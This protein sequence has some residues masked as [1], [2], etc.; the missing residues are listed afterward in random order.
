MVENIIRTNKFHKDTFDKTTEERR[1][2]VLNVAIEEFALNG[3]NATSINDISKKAQISIG[4]MYSYFASKE[5]LF[6]SIVNNAFFLMDDILRDVENNSSD[7]FDCVN[8]MIKASRIFAMNYP[9]LNRI[10]LD[11]T[12]QALSH[13][14]IKLSNAL[15]I[16]TPKVLNKFIMKA[17]M[18]GK[19]SGNLNE[20]VAAFCMDNIF[21]MYQFS[22]SS[23]YYKE[24]LKIYIGEENINDI[25]KLEDSI[26]EFIIGGLSN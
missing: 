6:L 5:D 15:E 21:T 24:R 1:Q 13:I 3:Y 10:Y 26:F 25:D 22:F 18:E 17:K 12:T 19:I 8:R 7:I 2:N 4:A 20:N 14:S 11:I 16:V 23:D 9:H